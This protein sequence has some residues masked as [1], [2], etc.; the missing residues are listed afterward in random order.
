M[1]LSRH[2]FNQSTRLT[3]HH[4]AFYPDPRLIR[5]VTKKKKKKC[6]NFLLCIITRDQAISSY[7]HLVVETSIAHFLQLLVNVFPCLL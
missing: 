2:S 6:K 1:S 3:V 7:M 5:N 4:I